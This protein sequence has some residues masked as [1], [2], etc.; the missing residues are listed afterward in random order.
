MSGF[1]GIRADGR[2]K[3]TPNK[4]TTKVRDSFACL[5]ENNID[6][7]QDDIDGLKPAERLNLLL[8]VAKFVIPTLKAIEVQDNGERERPQ[9]I[10]DMSTWL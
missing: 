4:N 10:I 5:L 8:Q 7:L 3:G 6:R 1:K 9:V 2:P